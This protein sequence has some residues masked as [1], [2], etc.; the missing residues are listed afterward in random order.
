MNPAANNRLPVRRSANPKKN[1]PVWA[2]GL[3]GI[4]TAVR[5]ATDG[6]PIWASLVAF[7]AC[8]AFG[9]ATQVFTAP[10]E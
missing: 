4:L 6:W 9:V 7:V 1:A 3:V 2:L 8:L 10:A 5:G